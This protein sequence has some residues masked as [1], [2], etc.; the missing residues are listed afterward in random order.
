LPLDFPVNTKMTPIPMFPGFDGLMTLSRREGVDIRPTLLRV[1]TDLYVQASA[2]SLEEEK[3]F[4]ALT[5]RLIQEVDD[6][7]RA[8]IRARLSIYP[9]TPRAIADQLEL[10]RTDPS[11]IPL[12]PRT[13]P[14]AVRTP[15][16]R[17]KRPVPSEMVALSMQ[18]NDALELNGMFFAADGHERLLI[19][20]NL[21]RAPL[22]PATRID[23]RR[24]ATS[25]IALE[26]MALEAD[27]IGFTQELAHVLILPLRLAQ[28]IVEDPSGEPLACA[29]RALNL[30]SETYERIILFLDPELGASVTRVYR[31]SRLYDSLSERIAL[32]ML[33]AWRGTSQASA[34]TKHQP[35]LYDDERQR[36]R[37]TQAPGKAPRIPSVT[38]PA[39]IPGRG[40]ANG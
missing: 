2:H 19:L 29:V 33:A 15:V 40:G 28:Q 6:A 22:K 9:L 16:E 7:T 4:V 11:S 39:A 38:Q 18:P 26:R 24:A 14:T 10:D 37:A 8:A 3:Q 32:I 34:R 36:P 1:L 20:Q 5:S 21:E 17:D 27:M 30:S 31:L 12:A 25:A 13:E 35:T 23:L